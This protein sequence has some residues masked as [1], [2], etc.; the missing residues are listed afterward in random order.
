VDVVECPDDEGGG[1]VLVL[2]DDAVITEPPLPE[3]PTYD[4][5]VRLYARWQSTPADC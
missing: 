3:P 4:E 1:Y 2:V 5:V